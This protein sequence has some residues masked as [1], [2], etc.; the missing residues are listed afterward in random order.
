[1]VFITFGRMS[2]EAHYSQLCLINV[3][4]FSVHRV[5]ALI[6]SPHLALIRVCEETTLTCSTLILNQ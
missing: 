4:L 6:I 5:S 3:L 1:M 2:N